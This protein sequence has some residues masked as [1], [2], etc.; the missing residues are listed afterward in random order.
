MGFSVSERV[1]KLLCGKS[2]FEKGLAYYQTESVDIIEVEEYNDSIPD[3]PRSRYEAIVQ[4]AIDYEVMVVIDIDGDV[5]AECNC[6]AYSHGG[7]FCKHIAAVMINVDALKTGR[8]RSELTDT[9]HLSSIE[10]TEILT[11]RIFTDTAQDKGGKSKDQQLVSSLLGMFSNHTPRPSGTGA[12]VDNRLP[13]NIEFTCKPFTYSY[14]HT[15]LGIEMKVGPK[16]L[17]IV[18]KIR[19]FLE[20]VHRGESFEFTKHFIYD[21]AIYSFRKE[22]NVVLQKLIDIVLN[23]KMYRDNVTPYSPYGEYWG[24]S[25]AGRPSFFWE[26]LQPALSEVSSVFLQQE[27]VLYEG[28]HVSNEA[29]PLSFE[30]EQAEED[31]YHLDIQGLEQIS[32][33]EDYGIVLSEGKLLKLSPQECIRLAEM[34]KMLDSSRRNGIDIAPEQMES[35]MD[36]VIPGLKKLGNVHI[37]DSIADRIVQHRLIARLYLDRVRDRL[38]AGL[39]FQY[40]D[41]VINPLDEKAHVRGTNLILLRDGEGE[42]RILELMEHE[43]FAK[44]EGG[45]IMTDEEGEYDFLY[46][47]IPL[48]EPLLSVYATSAVKARLFT[49]TTPPKVSISW[50]EKTDWLDFKF[51]MGGF[52]KLRLLWF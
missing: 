7:P 14:S 49:S 34:K 13:L 24:R 45:Y 17:Y 22:D 3:L 37:A 6:P 33:L 38:L 20:S 12:F 8:D 44:T 39:E 31:G 26:S 10:D 52:Q 29:P 35:F 4:G 18:Q 16:R 11:P 30:F 50:N 1:I 15:M 48:L 42:A 41:I 40:G 21:P 5:Q 27:E 25:V 19:G 36:K 23:E 9:S 32:V 28:I 47:T 2:I 46:H 43:S 51:D